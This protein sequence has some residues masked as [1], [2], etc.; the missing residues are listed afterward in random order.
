[1]IEEYWDK[2]GKKIKKEQYKGTG[3]GS[4]DFLGLKNIIVYDLIGI[5]IIPSTLSILLIIFLIIRRKKKKLKK[6]S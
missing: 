4:F 3:W 6:S 1:M 5:G 2:N